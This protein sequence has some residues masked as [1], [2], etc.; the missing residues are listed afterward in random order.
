MS[1]VIVSGFFLA[2]SAAPADEDEFPDELD[3]EAD[4]EVLFV[5]PEPLLEE[6]LLPLFCAADEDK[7]LS[8]AALNLIVAYLF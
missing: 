8:S 6:L 1:S 3:E 4:E 2:L 7:F 5:V